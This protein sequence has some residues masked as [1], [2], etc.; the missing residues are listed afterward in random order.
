MQD[1]KGKEGKGTF[2]S[3]L[4]EEETDE[5]ELIVN[6]D[7]AEALIKVNAIRMRNGQA[8]IKFR[9]RYGGRG[10]PPK[11]FGKCRFCKLNGHLQKVCRKRL[12]AGAP[13]VDEQGKPYANL[14]V[15]ALREEEEERDSYYSQAKN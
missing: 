14:G 12:A 1:K 2:V 8:P 4:K 9:P 10:G 3:S 13:C 5:T 7:E 15:A 11:T 6:E